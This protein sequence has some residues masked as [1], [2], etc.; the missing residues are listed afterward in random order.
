M[1][2]AIPLSDRITTALHTPARKVDSFKPLQ[3]AAVLWCSVLRFL[4]LCV[5]L[6]SWDFLLLW[7]LKNSIRVPFS[8]ASEG[9][10]GALLEQ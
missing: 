3:V 7:F 4:G 5:L 9:S 6:I 1:N 8:S 10:K 2:S